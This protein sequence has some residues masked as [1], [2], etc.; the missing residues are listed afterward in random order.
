MDWKT[1]SFYGF[2]IPQFTLVTETMLLVLS[3]FQ[4]YET[5]HKGTVQS[6]CH[7]T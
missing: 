3:W 7:R 2:V 6:D 5:S 1:T 4:K